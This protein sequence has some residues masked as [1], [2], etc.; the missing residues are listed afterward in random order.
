MAALGAAMA[1]YG[2]TRSYSSMLLKIWI[3]KPMYFYLGLIILIE[4]YCLGHG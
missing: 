1:G 4:L 3:D 2:Y